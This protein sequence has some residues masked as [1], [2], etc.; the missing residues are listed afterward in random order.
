MEQQFTPS[1]SY[2]HCGPDFDKFTM[3]RF[4]A[5]ENNHI[6]GHGLY[7]INSAPIAKRYAKYSV[8]PHLYTVTFN[9]NASAFYN[10]RV[11]P[12][13]EQAARYGKIKQEAGIEGR[14]T[15]PNYSIMKHGK[16]LPGE[17]FAIL[18]TKA[19]QALLIKHGVLGQIEEVDDGVFEVAIYDTSII[20]ITNKEAVDGGAKPAPRMSDEEWDAFWK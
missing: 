2:Y 15:P 3:D 12:S 6:L 19:G 5:G 8:N 10:I 14:N 11:K 20:N 4:G 7:F 17:V 13:D 1:D 16:G 18:G 9:A